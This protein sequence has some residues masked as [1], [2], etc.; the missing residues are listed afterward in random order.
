MF[1]LIFIFLNFLAAKHSQKSKV[2]LSVLFA[3][4]SLEVYFNLISFVLNR[5]L[6]RTLQKENEV[7]NL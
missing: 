3:N 2:I 6:E 7:K 1:S 4:S 5:A